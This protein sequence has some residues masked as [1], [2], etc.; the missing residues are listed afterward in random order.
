MSGGDSS[1][2]Y[3]V[4]GD[5]FSG[6]SASGEENDERR[7]QTAVMNAITELTSDI[8]EVAHCEVLTILDKAKGSGLVGVGMYDRYCTGHHDS[9]EVTRTFLGIASAQLKFDFKGKYESFMKIFNDIPS[10]DIIA[11]RIVD[12]VDKKL[13]TSKKVTSPDSSNLCEH[14]DSQDD[15]S[16]AFEETSEEGSKQQMAIG[17]PHLKTFNPD[18]TSNN[19]NSKGNARSEDRSEGPLKQESK[20]EVTIDMLKRKRSVDFQE[21]SMKLHVEKQ[22]KFILYQKFLDCLEEQKEKDKDVAKKLDDLKKEIMTLKVELK[23]QQEHHEAKLK[24]QEQVYEDK[25]KEQK[26]ENEKVINVERK[27]VQRLENQIDDLEEKL[28]KTKSDVK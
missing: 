9:K 5:N 10:L 25:L 6:R 8:V 26:S 17:L 23:Q 28:R 14:V 21:T 3:P 13:K 20:R 19:F 4:Y 22:E 27:R 12:D 18:N 1:A 16:K 15:Y 2:S 7:Y 24:E 11:T